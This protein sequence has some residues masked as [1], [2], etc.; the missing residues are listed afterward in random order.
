MAISHLSSQ[1][2]EGAELEL[3]HRAFAAPHLVRDFANA[4]LGEEAAFDDPAL[5]VG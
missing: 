3:L 1:C 2:F 4:A 5:I